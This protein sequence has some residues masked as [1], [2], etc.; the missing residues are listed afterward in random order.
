MEKYPNVKINVS[1]IKCGQVIKSVGEG[2][3][4][5]GFIGSHVVDHL[6]KNNYTV[7]VLD[8]LSTGNIKNLNKKVMGRGSQSTSFC[9]A[10]L[11]IASLA[12]SRSLSSGFMYAH[13][14]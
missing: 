13:F 12:S 5:I 10:R 3:I 7:I 14:C 1:G 6:L 8:N 9:S 11:A 4:D 2:E